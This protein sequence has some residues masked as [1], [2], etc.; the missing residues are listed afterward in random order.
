MIV[1]AYVLELTILK[2]LV[3]LQLAHPPNDLS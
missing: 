3:K 1:A 2:V